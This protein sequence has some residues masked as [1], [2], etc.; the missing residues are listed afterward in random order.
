MK[1]KDKYEWKIGSNPPELDEHSRTKH[2]VISEY[3]KRYTHT[4][5][6]NASIENLPLTIVDGFAGGGR[7]IDALTREPANGSPFLIL[8]SIKQAEIELNIGRRKPRT[9]DAEYHFVE[10]HKDHFEYL[11]N[12][13]ND[14][15][16]I[17][18]MNSKIFLYSSEFAKAAP[19]IIQRIKSRNRAQRSIFVLDQYAYKDVPFSLARNIL[20][21]LAGSE[22]I[23]TF[24]YDSLQAYLSDELDNRQALKNIN[25]DSHIEWNR[26][27]AFK[28]ANMWQ[29]AIQEQLA[30]AIWKASGAK[31]ITLFFV[32]PKK[33]LSYWL[34]HLSKVYRAR[35]VMMDLHWEH[36]N[37]STEFSHFLSDG[38]FSLGYKAT[39][40]P[41]Q[42][43]LDFSD[44]FNFGDTSALKCIQKLSTEIP[45]LIYDHDESRTF[46]DLVDEIGSL[47]PASE[48]HIKQALQNS[49]DTNELIVV[50]KEG[51]KRRSSNQMCGTDVITY[52]QKQLFI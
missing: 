38:L 50:T 9:I 15:E 10:S 48:T 11:R 12:E 29:Q 22:I 21:S 34:V 8:E 52:K 3:I 18:Y 42:N 7:Y 13:L 19:A 28:E 36:S 33:G 26:L 45:K 1:K 20:S 25:L 35:D 2:L 49:I 39:K 4:Y 17:E 5:M 14:S 46:S 40:T 16:F 51:G 37:T 30:N 23:L 44:D 24:N 41:G 27:N 32:T 6:S 43:D 47:T 31:H